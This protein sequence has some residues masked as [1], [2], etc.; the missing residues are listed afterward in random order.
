MTSTSASVLHRMRGTICHPVSSEAHARHRSSAALHMG[1]TRRRFRP[2]RSALRCGAQAEPSLHT[3]PS[4]SNAR[5]SLDP[6]TAGAQ[7]GQRRRKRSPLFFLSA[8]RASPLRG[9]FRVRNAQANASV[10]EE[11]SRV[12][13][14]PRPERPPVLVR[15]VDACPLGRVRS[16]PPWR[17]QRTQ[18]YRA[19]TKL[20]WR[21]RTRQSSRQLVL[22]S[23]R[24]RFCSFDIIVPAAR[25]TPQGLATAPYR[26]DACCTLSPGP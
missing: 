26:R 9:G 22:D 14:Q 10:R 4:S 7:R 16:A 15:L 23:V 18:Q 1:P 25:Q 11:G 13:G 3:P 17:S 2:I 6:S 5:L 20:R 24:P 8:I 19:H 12:F 21:H